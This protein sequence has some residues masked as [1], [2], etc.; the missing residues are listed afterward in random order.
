M[1]THVKW[2]ERSL[3]GQV[4]VRALATVRPLRHLGRRYGAQRLGGGKPVRRRPR[5]VLVSRWPAS[6]CCSRPTRRRKGPSELRDC[7]GLSCAE[8]AKGIPTCPVA[9]TQIE[10]VEGLLLPGVDSPCAG[11]R[12]GVGQRRSA[13]LSSTATSV[14]VPDGTFTSVL[15][16]RGAH[17]E[18][19]ALARG[20]R[21]IL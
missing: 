10:G 9:E 3:G 13:S 16:L 19:G 2:C 17:Y 14:P 11:I 8:T 1:K 6:A 20:L 18:Y 7:A 21:I 5:L 15:A 4:P 12:L